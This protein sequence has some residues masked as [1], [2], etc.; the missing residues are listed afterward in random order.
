MP[1]SAHRPGPRPFGALGRDVGALHRARVKHIKIGPARDDDYA[2]GRG[3]E[4]IEDVLAR[5]F[6]IGDDEI[7]A[8]HDRIVE[9][10]GRGARVVDAVKGGDE[11]GAGE[12]GRD[13]GA[14]GR[15]ARA[16]VHDVH[17]A[18]ADKP[19]EAER[20]GE[21]DERIFGL[22]RE[23][24]QLAAGRL[25][26]RLEATAG[27]GDQSEPPGAIDRIRYFK[28]GPLHPASIKLRGD[29]QNSEIV[30]F[31]QC[32]VRREAW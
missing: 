29:L 20:I 31:L 3:G 4:M 19:R 7:V 25:E 18:L 21:R 11:R 2:L 10:L 23:L 9:V 32:F 6:G 30:T 26:V 17:A 14:P 28:R 8:R 24:D 27:A 13:P 22:Q 15:R 16:G 1:R 12:L 5:I